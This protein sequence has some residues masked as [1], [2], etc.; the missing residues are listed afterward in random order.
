MKFSVGLLCL[1]VGL[2]PNLRNLQVIG[3]ETDD[4]SGN[5]KYEGQVLTSMPTLKKQFS[6][7]GLKADMILSKINIERLEDTEFPSY[8]PG[9]LVE[10]LS[11]AVVEEHWSINV[12]KGI[13]SMLNL[14]STVS[15]KS[16]NENIMKIHTEM[17]EVRGYNDAPYRF[18]C[19]DS[20]HLIRPRYNFQTSSLYEF[21]NIIA[22]KYLGLSSNNVVSG[23]KSIGMDL[24]K[25]NK[26]IYKTTKVSLSGLVEKL[27]F[28]P[29][30]QL[31]AVYKQV[32][33]SIQTKEAGKVHRKILLDTV[34][35]AGT[36][37]S[38]KFLM[39]LVSKGDIRGFE[40]VDILAGFQ[41]PYLIPNEYAMNTLKD[42]CVSQEQYIVKNPQIQVGVCLGLA[43]VIKKTCMIGNN[44]DQKSKIFEHC[45]PQN[46]RM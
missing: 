35:V 14:D 45:V 37:A 39:K 32:N 23:I 31:E 16:S 15:K 2:N 38:I 8:L 17:L 7:F 29:E 1:T 18:N 30:E 24:L 6:G 13:L 26:D 22:M 4:I 36:A 34:S 46:L 33:V 9:S 25:Q 3:R 41:E 28:L 19:T 20:Q 43:Q 42:Y 27:A 44:E 10:K 5:Y 40:I 11:F 21:Q 12:K